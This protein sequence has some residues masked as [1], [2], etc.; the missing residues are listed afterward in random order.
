MVIQ[1]K[2]KPKPKQPEKPSPTS[3]ITKIAS[4]KKFEDKEYANSI[5]HDVAKL[6]APIMHENNF[7]VGL[8]C[9]M[10]PKSGNLLGLNVNKGQKIMLRLRYHSNSRLFLPM[11]DIIGTMLHELTHNLYGPH[12][13]QFYKF[14]D[15]LKERFE[16]IQYDPQ[17]VKG[18]FCEENKLGGS[19]RLFNE[20]KSI[21]DKRIEA[22]S[23]P[24]YKAERRKLGGTRD[25]RAMR[26]L[27]LE[28]A[29]RRL[30]DS[31]QCDINEKQDAE[32]GDD[33]LEIVEIDAGPVPA[34]FTDSTASPSASPTATGPTGPTI[35]PISKD[36]TDDT[37]K[38]S[39]KESIKDS[40]KPQQ[41]T[42]EIIDLESPPPSPELIVLD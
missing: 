12:N 4:L 38:S 32:P 16:E 25:P 17:L 42:P 21:R 9:E 30:R 31:K 20:Y 40:P 5:L 26:L 11:S 15:K 10:F 37:S 1:G 41:N 27:A 29:E 13:D 24:R 22:V 14:L 3:R 7:R 33:E 18:Y 23:K 28:A 34:N 2:R 19:G 6:V 36:T 8:L 35:N 39:T